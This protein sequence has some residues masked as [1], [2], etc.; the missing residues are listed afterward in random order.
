MREKHVHLWVIPGAA[1]NGQNSQNWIYTL[2]HC[3][4]SLSI[5]KCHLVPA[6]KTSKS[7]LTLPQG[8]NLIPCQGRFLQV[9]SVVSDLS[10]ANPAQVSLNGLWPCG[11]W[12][13]FRMRSCKVTQCSTATASTLVAKARKGIPWCLSTSKGSFLVKA[14][15]F[16]ICR[17]V[18]PSYKLVYKRH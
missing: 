18:P 13:A 10:D 8:D 5:L 12:D 7:K 6:F 1:K 16:S 2:I 11:S 3:T 17:M 15:I 4:V 9:L 14:L